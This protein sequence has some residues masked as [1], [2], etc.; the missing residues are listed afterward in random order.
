MVACLIWYQ[1]HGGDALAGG[2]QGEHQPRGE[3]EGQRQTHP[4][5]TRSLLR[6]I[7]MRND[8]MID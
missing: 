2:Q 4:S 5:T 7:M 3:D 8:R 1:H 6:G